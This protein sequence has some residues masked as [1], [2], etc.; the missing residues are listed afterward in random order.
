MLRSIWLNFV[1][2]MFKGKVRR[3]FCLCKVCWSRKRKNIIEKQLFSE[4]RFSMSRANC[5]CK[6]AHCFI[7]Q[8]GAN[9]CCS[10]IIPL[11]FKWSNAFRGKQRLKWLLVEVPQRHALMRN[12]SKVARVPR[13]GG[14]DVYYSSVIIIFLDSDMHT[15]SFL[16]SENPVFIIIMYLSKLSCWLLRNFMNRILPQDNRDTLLTSL[17]LPLSILGEL[18]VKLNNKSNLCAKFIRAKLSSNMHSNT[19][20]HGTSR[21]F[22]LGRLGASVNAYSKFDHI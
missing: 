2:T 20:I 17:Y 3:F 4:K 22:H 10:N 13:M 8:K 21:P 14:V 5:V 9:L 11:R 15:I 19:N 1:L 12:I 6:T 7:C 18:Q 16:M